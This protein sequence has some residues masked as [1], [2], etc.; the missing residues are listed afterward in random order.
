M[1]ISGCTTLLEDAADSP[2]AN[3]ADAPWGAE[4]NALLTQEA[5][6]RRVHFANSPWGRNLDAILHPSYAAA[7]GRRCRRVTLSPEQPAE[8][9]PRIVLACQIAETKQWQPVRLLHLDGRAM[10]SAA[11]TPDID[12]FAP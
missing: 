6:N 11:S 3:G 9:Q 7:S 12:E 5:S 2:Q 10:L 4:F 1:L 8:Q